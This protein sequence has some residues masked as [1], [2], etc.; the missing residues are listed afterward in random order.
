[1]D[2]NDSEKG[3]TRAMIRKAVKVRIDIQENTRKVISDI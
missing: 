3:L 2:M 1:M